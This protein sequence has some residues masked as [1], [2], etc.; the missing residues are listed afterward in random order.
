M[1]CFLKANQKCQKSKCNMKH[2]VSQFLCSIQY[3]KLMCKFFRRPL[4]NVSLISYKNCF[5]CLCAK[6]LHVRMHIYQEQWKIPVGE[7]KLQHTRR[8]QKLNSWYAVYLDQS[9]QI[10]GSGSGREVQEAGAEEGA[11]VC[12][13]DDEGP[14]G[15]E[16]QRLH[17]PPGKSEVGQERGHQARKGIIGF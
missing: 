12:R 3:V 14:A 6:L 15:L 11:R 8:G 4:L 2:A 9:A 10:E 5:E 1:K 17:G 16:T 13:W 7:R